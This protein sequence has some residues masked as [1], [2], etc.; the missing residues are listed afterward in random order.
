V[1]A[2]QVQIDGGLFEIAM[3]EQDLDGAKVGS[4]FEQMRSK[5]VP[6]VCGWICLCSRP[7]RSA[8]C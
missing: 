2:G 1:L 8:A 6:Q 4:G 3:S 5:A 7:A